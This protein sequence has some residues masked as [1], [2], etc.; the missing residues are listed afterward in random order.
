[1]ERI[2][3]LP[4]AC[5]S[6][7]HRNHFISWLSSQWLMNSV[8]PL[9]SADDEKTAYLGILEN[10]VIVLV[11]RERENGDRLEKSQF[12]MDV[13]TGWI[14]QVERLLEMASEDAGESRA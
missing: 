2:T 13:G 7:A 3:R 11:D 14:W 8:N 1:M 4:P 5:L 9:R 6:L 10:V 12:E